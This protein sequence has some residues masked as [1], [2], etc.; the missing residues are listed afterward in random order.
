MLIRRISAIALLMFTLGTTAA[1]TAAPSPL[2]GAKIAQNQK[3]NRPAG[4]AGGLFD[5]LNLSADQKQKMQAVRTRYKDQIS[6]QMQAVRQAGQELQTMMSSTTTNDTQMREQNTK[7]IGL[8][9][10][11]EDV[12]FESMLAMREVLTPEQRSQLA[13]LM[14]QRRDTAK[15]RRMTGQ[16]P[17]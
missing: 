8:R 14:Q 2:Q 13:Q 12:Q 17:Q 6:Q 1:A 9:Q 15:N 16:K 7:I 5:K 10:K 4:K 11:L 3:P